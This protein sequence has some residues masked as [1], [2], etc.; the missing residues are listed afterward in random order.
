MERWRLLDSENDS[1]SNRHS[2]FDF[3]RDTNLK[4]VLDRIYVELEHYASIIMPVSNANLVM[5]RFGD[6]LGLKLMG[7]NQNPNDMHVVGTKIFED[8]CNRQP[9]PQ[10]YMGEFLHSIE[11]IIPLPRKHGENNSV[12]I[13][14]AKAFKAVKTACPYIDWRTTEEF[15]ANI[16]Y[17]YM[18][19]TDEE[20]ALAGVSLKS[21]LH[22][23]AEL[24][25]HRGGADRQLSP[26]WR[27]GNV[28]R[29]D[30]ERYRFLDGQ[31][32]CLSLQ[33][34]CPFP[35]TTFLQAIPVEMKVGKIQDDLRLAGATL[36]DQLR[37][38]MN[39]V[40]SP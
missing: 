16:M 27:K 4:K 30:E 31:D 34:E 21:V 22:V 40:Y 32:L 13:N 26:Q 2:A 11:C 9:R 38:M 18:R 14:F 6:T 29:L 39:N 36:Y 8:L 15:I 35:K 3:Q 10:L 37:A 33:V 20:R 1:K 28:E 24:V 23:T 12:S 5:K 17:G 19:P 25:H 7:N